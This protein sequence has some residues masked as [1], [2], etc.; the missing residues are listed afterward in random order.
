MADG[1]D[2]MVKQCKQ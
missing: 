1:L 2:N